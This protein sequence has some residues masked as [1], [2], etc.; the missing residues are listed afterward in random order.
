MSWFILFIA[1]LL[2]AGWLVG[3]QKSASF[4]KPIFVVLAAFS[5][6]LSLVLFSVAARTIPIS[7]AYM[8]WLAIGVTAI[9]VINHYFF[10]ISISSQQLFFLC[11][12]FIGIAGLKLSN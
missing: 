7:Q 5:M 3:I 9:S 8:V 12:I 11:L 4:T 2:E 1:G 10:D 6:I